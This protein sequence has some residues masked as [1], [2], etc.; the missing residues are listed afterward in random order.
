MK[1]LIEAGANVNITDMHGEIA[2][3]LAAAK[4]HVNITRLLIEVCKASGTA[5][6]SD[7]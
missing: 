6:I 7:I 4:K 1:T 2:L 5:Y 3:H